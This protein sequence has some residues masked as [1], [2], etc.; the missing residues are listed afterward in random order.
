MSNEKAGGRVVVGIDGSA[1][2]AEALRWA[3]RYATSTHAV[4]DAVIAWQMPVSYGW[5]YATDGWRPDV[6]A[7]KLLT[8]QVDQVFGAQRPTDLRLVV[9]EGYPARVLIE[10]SKDAALLVVGSRG[11]GGFYGLLLG[12]VSA[13]CA[14]HAKCPVVVVH[15][16]TSAE[17]QR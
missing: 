9:R 5:A 13:N 4:I 6:D 15:R 11:H 10:A 17:V 14:E 3:A 8:A 12:S 1:G 16:S 2:S 7:E